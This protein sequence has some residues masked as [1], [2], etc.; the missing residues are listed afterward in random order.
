MAAFTTVEGE[1]GQ[2]VAG[3]VIE[4]DLLALGLFLPAFLMSGR[5]RLEA[6]FWFYLAFM[7]MMLASLLLATRP[8]DG[9]IEYVVHLFNFVV[10]IAL[11]NLCVNARDFS[12]SD[13]LYAFFYA[14]AVVAVLCLLQFFVFPNWFG[15]RQVGGLV[16]T[17]RNTGQAG[18][19]FGTALAVLLPAMVVGLIRRSAFNVMAMLLIVMCLVLT[20]KRAALLGFSVGLVGLLLAAALTGSLEDRRRNLTFFVIALVLTPVVFQIYDFAVQNVSGLESRF[21]RKV[22][23]FSVDEFMTKF[24]G[25]NSAAALRAFQDRPLLGVGPNNIVGEYTEKYEIHSTP[26]SILSSTGI[27]G[28][29]VYLLFLGHLLWTIWKAGAGRLMENRF[30]RLAFPMVCGLI[31]SWGYTYHVRKREFWIAY[32]VIMFGAFLIK[33]YQRQSSIKLPAQRTGPSIYQ[34]GNVFARSA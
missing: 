8:G 29:L 11:F 10:G 27:L 32:A 19:Y 12:L 2:G 4:A 34:T 24:F 5:I 30:M 28:F 26:L 3:R 14:A 1:A 7:G 9:I 17:F 25:E 22:T 18:T 31:V 6:N 33:R 20:V 21:E 15:G 23:N 16:G 13:V